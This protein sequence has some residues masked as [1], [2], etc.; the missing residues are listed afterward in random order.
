MKKTTSKETIGERFLNLFPPPYFL[1]LKTAGVD[2]SDSSIKV[3]GFKQTQHGSIPDFLEERKISSDIVHQGGIK[4][5]ESLSTVLTVLRRKYDMNFIRAALPEEKAYLF[6]TTVP[7]SQDKEQI[8]NNIEFKLEEY[9]P[10]PPSESIFDYDVIQEKRDTIDVSVTV[11]P[12][13]VIKNY[14]KVFKSAGLT[15]VSFALEGQAIANAVV[16][17][18]DTKTYMIVDF[19]RTRSGISIVRNGIVSFTSTIEVGGN[20]LTE[21]IMKYFKVDDIE[22]QRIKNQKEF[23]NNKENKQ[24]YDSLMS[25]VSALKDEI[26]RHFIYWNTKDTN[27][28]KEDKISKIILCGGN[29]SLVGLPEFLS[30]GIDAPVEKAQVWQNAFSYDKYIPSISYEES[31][32]YATAIGLALT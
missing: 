14:Q 2:I 9:V 19:G 23:I 11:F 3:L 8:F 32:S 16:P 7:N 21:A 5:V 27:K 10:I 13:S 1:N 30:L 22:A 28:K 20:K 29:A 4:D 12:K 17:R 15:P 18:G 25:T 26:N 6:Q 24:L 31:L